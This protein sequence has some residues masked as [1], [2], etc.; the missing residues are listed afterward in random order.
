MLHLGF[1]GSKQLA[2]FRRRRP[3]DVDAF[4]IENVEKGKGALALCGAVSP[5]GLR[6]KELPAPLVVMETDTHVTGEYD[7]VLR[8]YVA[9]V[10]T[11]FFNRR[12]IGRTM[13][14]DFRQFPMP[15]EVFWPGPAD[16][17]CHTWYA[18]G[19][20]IMPGAPDY[21]VMFPMRWSIA[22]D[23][24]EF[25]LASSPDNLLWNFVPG[26]A[27]CK[28]GEPGAWDA[29]VVTPGHGL[30]ESGK[31]RLALLYCGT[32]VTHKYPRRPPLG[33]LAWAWWPKGRLVALRCPLEGEFVTWPLR[34][35]GRTVHLNFRSQ[36]TGF[37]QV[38][39]RN[40]DLSPLPGRTFESCD[41]L[42]GNH[43]D[44]VV[45][46]KGQSDLGHREGSAIVLYFRLRNVD[47]YAVQFR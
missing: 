40:A 15:D 42:S 47:L 2:R 31:D 16:D 43:L 24:F 37:I 18:N 10:R 45:T 32:P 5:D 1:L 14:D 3:D 23:H 12:S 22:T 17:P 19:K 25:H 11:W 44:R 39:A 46:W 28:P 8:K 13:S 9:Y 20:T 7:P 27:V 26:G 30:V 38:E 21:H 6:W 41:P 35:D 36:K 29:G 33:G 34:F 4:A